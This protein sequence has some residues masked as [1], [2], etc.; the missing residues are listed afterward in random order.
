MK[1]CHGQL[2]HESPLCPAYPR[3]ICESCACV[4][5]RFSWY[6]GDCIEVTAVCLI[7]VCKCVSSGA[8][9]SDTSKRWFKGDGSQPHKEKKKNCVC[10]LKFTVSIDFLSMES[11]R[12][13]K[14][15]E[16]AV[17]S[18]TGCGSCGHIMWDVLICISSCILWH[19]HFLTSSQGIWFSTVRYLRTYSLK[20]LIIE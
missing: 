13:M 16:L 5:D 19:R 15:F 9:D 4:L 10:F 6:C 11:C 2:G 20:T 1:S 3:C 18:H 8:G 7:M 12:R 14:K 17:L